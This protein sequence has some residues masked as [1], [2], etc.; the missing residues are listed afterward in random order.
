MHELAQGCIRFWR[1]DEK[2]TGGIPMHKIDMGSPNV[3]HV[4]CL[5]GKVST[6]AICTTQVERSSHGSWQSM[7]PVKSCGIQNQDCRE[8][9]QQCTGLT[10][11]LSGSLKPLST[12]RTQCPEGSCERPISTRHNLTSRD[13]IC[14]VF[15]HV[16]RGISVGPRKSH[17]QSHDTSPGFHTAG[18]VLATATESC[19]GGLGETE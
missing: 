14:H 15:C 4:I 12:A 18:K 10:Q 11:K 16:S 13:M 2:A 1:L 9:F 8:A 19:Q 6:G 5:L 17:R 7:S 3:K